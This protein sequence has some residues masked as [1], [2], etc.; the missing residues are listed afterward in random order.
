MRHLFL[1][2]SFLVFVASCASSRPSASQE[3]GLL[4]LEIEPSD[5]TIWV[6]D[7]YLGQANGWLEGTLRVPVGV[8]R[9]EL[10]AEGF[11]TQRFDIAITTHEE[12]ILRLA[13]QPELEDLDDVSEES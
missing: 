9:L 4:R 10:Q 13:M 12:V 8:R 1:L 7:Q 6:D 2:L 11:M 3:T 5:A